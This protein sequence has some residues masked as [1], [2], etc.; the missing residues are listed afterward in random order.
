MRTTF[1]SPRHRGFGFAL[2]ALMF[3]TAAAPLAAQ[4][5]STPPK[6][7]VPATATTARVNPGMY[8]EFGKI[9]QVSGLNGTAQR[10]STTS[11]SAPSAIRFTFPTAYQGDVKPGQP[12]WLTLDA[13]KA[14]FTG[15]PIEAGKMTTTVGRG[16]GNGKFLVTTR[17]IKLG[18]T[19][20][21][22]GWAKIESEDFINGFT[23]VAWFELLD[24][25]G[26][27]LHQDRA[28]CR[29]VNQRSGSTERWDKQV[30]PEIA[31]QTKTIRMYHGH[32]GC[33]RDRFSEAMEDLKQAGE[34]AG[35]WVE[36]AAAVAA[37]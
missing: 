11:T 25:D 37:M 6:R 7:T 26:N 4:L 5:R 8:R 1:Q 13:T 27:P 29:G 24:H 28:I 36:V 23:G 20:M 15:F 19:G 21:I 9:T 35:A 12:V 10:A 18:P 34:A 2:A 30:P 32:M 3:L 22:T 33:G 14:R 31:V 16:S 17:D